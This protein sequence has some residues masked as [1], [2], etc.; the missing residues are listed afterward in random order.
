LFGHGSNLGYQRTT[1]N[2]ED[3]KLSIFGGH[4]CWIVLVNDAVRHH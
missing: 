1:T 2:F 4:S 3:L